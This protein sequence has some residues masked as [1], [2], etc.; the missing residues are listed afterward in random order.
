MELK[1]K[2]ILVTGGAGFIGSHLVDRIVSENP[3]NLVV[4]DNF[5]LG[6]EDNLETAHIGY[7]DLKVYR[8]D[9]ADL[10]AM[11][12][13]VEN[14]S[15]EVVF[16][17][18]AIPLPTSHQ[19]PS[20]TVETNINIT[21][22]FCE[23]ARWNLI[24]TLVHCSSSEAYG[25]AQYIPMDELHPML[26][27]TPYAASKAASDQIVLSYHRTFGIDTVIVRPFNNFG[28]RQNP[29]T[30]AG[31]IPI[32]VN[33]VINHLPIEIYGDGK[34]T[35]DFIFVRDTAEAFVKIYKNKETRGKEINIATG[36][37]I[38]VNELVEKLLVVL[39]KPDHSVIHT[40]PRP[41]DVRRHCGDI[42][43]VTQLVGIKPPALTEAH[44]KETV[45]WYIQRNQK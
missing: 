44:L 34:Q 21:L 11:R 17:L 41:G 25:S 27:S 15:I 45:D 22:T 42:T 5:F 24:K 18:A 38:S 12:Q 13:L 40:E 35:R 28:P 36:Q 14:E 6:R 1:G 32:V 10:A 43:L 9:A 23:L 30:Y 4:V 7:P 19:Y 31:I 2:N 20:W 16:N 8:L 37:E 33:R 3:S 26:A 29:G 39:G